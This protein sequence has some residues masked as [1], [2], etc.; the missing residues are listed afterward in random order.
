MIVSGK[1]TNERHVC[2]G[3]SFATDVMQ[4]DTAKPRA[5][6]SAGPAACPPGTSPPAPRRAAPAPAGWGCS[7]APQWCGPPPPAGPSRQWRGPAGGKGCLFTISRSRH[8]KLL[9][10]WPAGLKISTAWR[11]RV[12]KALPTSCNNIYTPQF[13][14]TEI[15]QQ[16]RSPPAP[17]RTAAG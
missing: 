3:F 13:K 7:A 11:H 5:W 6:C 2:N 4:H 12:A 8:S 10:F 14:L 16:S 17:P 15:V 9:S 1:P